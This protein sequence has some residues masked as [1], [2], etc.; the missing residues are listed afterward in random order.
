MTRS[1]PE[2]TN[3]YSYFASLSALTSLFFQYYT[4]E[5][6]CVLVFLDINCI[7]VLLKRYISNDK[8]AQV[9]LEINDLLSRLDNKNSF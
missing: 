6:T 4:L 2:K 9:Y 3:L 8:L 5:I 7:E 1:L